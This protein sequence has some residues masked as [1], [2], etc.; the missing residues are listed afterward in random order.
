MPSPC[1]VTN[2]KSPLSFALI[3][4]EVGRPQGHGTRPTRRTPR[5]R[6]HCSPMKPDRKAQGTQWRGRWGGGSL[7]E[8]GWCLQVANCCIPT[9]LFYTTHYHMRTL[10][11]SSTTTRQSLGETSN[12]DSLNSIPSSWDTSILEGSFRADKSSLSPS[13]AAVT[14]QKGID[15]FRLILM[16]KF[17]TRFKFPRNHFLGCQAWLQAVLPWGP[18]IRREG[19][20][21][22]SVGRRKRD[23][24]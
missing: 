2:L 9:S 19:R 23:I 3:S 13:K 22:Y 6:R 24:L 7:A 15:T 17:Q 1:H 20:L 16:S 14:L 4:L 21:R 18:R 5:G 8:R 10:W 12:T 11:Y